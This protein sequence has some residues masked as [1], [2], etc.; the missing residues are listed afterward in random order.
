MSFAI[1]GMGT[2]LPSQSLSQERA[3][4]L[5]NLASGYDDEQSRWVESLYRGAGSDADIS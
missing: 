4:E 5:I 3:A 2:A 1:W